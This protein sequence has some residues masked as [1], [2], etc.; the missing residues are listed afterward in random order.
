MESPTMDPLLLPIDSF[1]M[2]KDVQEN[3]TIILDTEFNYSIF[4]TDFVTVFIDYLATILIILTFYYI[5]DI[6]YYIQ[7]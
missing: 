3:L 6:I 1:T 5:F 2:I 4:L 7:L